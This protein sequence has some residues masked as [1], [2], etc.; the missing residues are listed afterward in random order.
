MSTGTVAHKETEMSVDPQILRMTMRL[1][2]SG[3]TVLTAAQDGKRFG[4]TASSFTSVSLNP[5]LILACLYK[6]S[7]TAKV[8]LEVG[9]FAVSILR[10]G[11]DDLAEQFAGH[12]TLPDDT[13]RFYNVPTSAQTTG[14]PILNE[15]IAWLDCRVHAVHDGGTHWIIVGEVLATGRSEDDPNPLIYHNRAYRSIVS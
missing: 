7:E 10:D 3:V 13:D 2:A 5:P 15:A 9:N 4:T 14:S 11:Q 1:W 6:T 12:K 8:I